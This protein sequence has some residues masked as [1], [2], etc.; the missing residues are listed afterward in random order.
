[1]LEQQG[2]LKP[3]LIIL[4][5]QLRPVQLGHRLDQTETQTI[6]RS[7][8]AGLQA[9]EALQYLLPLAG[10]YPGAIIAD[11]EPQAAIFSHGLQNNRAALRTKFAGIVEQVT[12]RLGQ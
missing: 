10:G 4:Q 12:D 9:H 5:P 6:A 2:S 7:A 1:M 11:N 3:R 8:A